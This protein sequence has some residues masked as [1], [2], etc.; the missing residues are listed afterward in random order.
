MLILDLCQSDL[1][2]NVKLALP[3]LHSLTGC[4]STSSF[5]G[6]GKIKPFKLM[7]S[8][9][10]FMHAMQLLGS[11]L[12]IKK[13]EKQILEEFVCELYDKHCRAV[14]IN[15]ARYHLLSNS[16]NTSDPNQLPPTQDSLYLHIDSANFQA[17]I[18]KSALLPNIAKNLNPSKHGC[19][20]NDGH[21]EVKW[22]SQNSVP[23]AL[24]EFLVCKC[25]KH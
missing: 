20:C 21:S 9:H 12:H 10:R 25:R 4:D 2:N 8:S 3:G 17:F 18:W 15:T 22:M 5:H 6:K 24:L 19:I 23:E 16:N 1:A 7:K 11:S 13:A 14:D